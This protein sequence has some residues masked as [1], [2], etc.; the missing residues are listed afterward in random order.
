[1]NGPRGTGGDSLPNTLSISIP[2]VQ[3]SVLLAGL[4]DEVAAS[5]GAACHAVGTASISSVLLAMKVGLDK[6]TE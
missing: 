2:G 1:M 4:A 6:N 5:A 3:A